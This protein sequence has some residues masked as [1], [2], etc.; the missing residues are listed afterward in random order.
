MKTERR[1]E[2]QTNKLADWMGKRIDD[3]KPYGRMIVGAVGLVLILSVAFLYFSKQRQ[4]DRN[5]GWHEYYR[6]LEGGNQPTLRSLA[7]RYKNSEVGRWARFSVAEIERNQGNVKLYDDRSESNELLTA[8]QTNYQ[9]VATSARHP[10]LQRRAIFGLAQAYEARN[11]LKNAEEKYREVADRWPESSIGSLA[12]SAV[13]RL[14]GQRE[15]YDWFFD[16]KPRPAVSLGNDDSIDFGNFSESSGASD[17]LNSF[18]DKPSSGVDGDANNLDNDGTDSDGTESGGLNL[19]DGDVNVPPP[20]SE[21][22]N[23]QG[24]SVSPEAGDL[25]LENDSPEE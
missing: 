18:D 7:Q 23:L 25:E 16:Q 10:F 11:D 5:E 13:Q 2:L 1:H 20:S 8:A 6:A 24:E 9:E 3:A 15:F 22:L 4:A 14:N 17:F 21:D 12:S 19:D